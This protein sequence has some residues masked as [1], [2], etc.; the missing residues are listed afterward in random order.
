MR[1]FS[2][3]A[4]RPGGT[5]KQRPVPHS[6]KHRRLERSNLFFIYCFPRSFALSA[7]SCGGMDKT[8]VRKI[9]E[10]R[11]LSVFRKKD[12]TGL[13]F[14]GAGGYAE[15]IK[16]QLSDSSKVGEG[17][18][19]LY[20]SG[21]ILGTH[22]GLYQFTCGQRKGLNVP[23][24]KALYVVKTDVQNN[25][26]WVGEESCL[27]SDSAR[28]TGLNWLDEVREGERVRVKIRF[29]HEGCGA[30]V[31]K[32]DSNRVL[33]K[34]EKAQKAVTPGQAGVMYRGDQLLGGGSIV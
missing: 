3:R 26:L 10:E 20:P 25:T 8:K 27:Y 12:S 1:L 29:H 22:T 14:T 7:V 21:E 13:C 2:Y 28:L 33:L 19:K 11:G 23:S 18:I 34:F 24:N 4:L 31:Y 6:P 16:K 9:A 15:F 30:R 32:E 17:P 5:N